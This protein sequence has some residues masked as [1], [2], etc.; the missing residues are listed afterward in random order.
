MGEAVLYHEP[1]GTRCLDIGG[2]NAPG[3]NQVAAKGRAEMAGDDIRLT[4]VA[5]TRAQSQVVAWWAPSW[6]EPNGGLSRLLRGRVPNQAEVPDSL[7]AKID[8]A[9]A[10][11]HLRK[12][13]TAGGPSLEV[14]EP[15]TGGVEPAPAVAPADLGV[16]RFDRAIDVAWRRTSYS[17][18]VRAGR[19]VRR[20]H[21]GAGALGA[22]RRGGR[23]ARR[24]GADPSPRPP[25]RRPCRRRWPTCPSGASF[26]SLVH[27][28]LEE[29]DPFADDLAAEL[30]RH[31]EEQRSQWGVD[32]PGRGA[33]RGPRAAA[34]HVPRPAG[35]RADPGRDRTRRPAV[36]ARLRDPAGRRRPRPRRPGRRPGHAGRRRRAAATSTCR[37]TTRCVPTPRGSARPGSATSRCAATSPARSTS[38]SA[39][40]R[41][42]A[43]AT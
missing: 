11:D 8:D 10:L 6:D 37:P 36:R 3:Y 9:A 32:D 27:G 18:L 33:R 14:A 42:T 21:L 34:P 5:L 1:D 17:G 29:A 13:E 16:R 39:C 2:S 26:G 41:A 28:V 31:V 35:G 30:R 15:A 12:W 40:R 22:R 38:C 19:G 7:P 20:R 25:R 23:R 4:Y 43:T 24:R